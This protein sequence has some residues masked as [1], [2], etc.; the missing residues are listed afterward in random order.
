MTV[1]GVVVGNPRPKSRKLDVALTVGRAIQ[2]SLG[3]A[4]DRAA[5]LDLRT[6]TYVATLR[7]NIRPTQLR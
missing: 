4:V 5:E 2:A 7:A 3:I 6:S 1:V